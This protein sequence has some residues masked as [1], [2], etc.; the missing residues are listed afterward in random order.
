MI[1]SSNIYLLS[2]YKFYFQLS[3]ARRRLV[4]RRKCGKI[5]S[6]RVKMKI[7][8]NNESKVY[9]PKKSVRWRDKV[10]RSKDIGKLPKKP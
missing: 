9:E 5:E 3:R 10:C 6:E 4:V 2:I 8:D 7:R 1:L